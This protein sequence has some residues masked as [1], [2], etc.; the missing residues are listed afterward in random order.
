MPYKRLAAY[1]CMPQAL[2]QP[3]AARQPLPM[4]VRCAPVHMCTFIA[5][6]PL[7]IFGCEKFYDY[8]RLYHIVCCCALRTP[9]PTM[10]PKRFA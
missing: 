5:H 2:L 4:Q 6:L 10:P 3:A 1:F 8:A 7:A 9:P